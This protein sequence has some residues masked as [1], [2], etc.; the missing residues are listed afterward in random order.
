MVYKV[1]HLMLQ[2]I[3]GR[4]FG[5][6]KVNEHESD[7]I[8]YSNYSW[9]APIKT[10]VA[11]LRPVDTLG[12]HLS[13]YVVRYVNRY[14]Q[15]SPSDPMFLASSDEAVDQFRL[16]ASFHF[17]SFFHLDRS[18]V[19]VLCRP[20]PSHSTDS[21]PPSIFV[22]RFFESPKEMGTSSEARRFVQFV[23]KVLSMPRKSYRLLISCMAGF[24]DALESVGRNFDLAYSMMVYMLEALSK[25]GDRPKVIWD[26]YDQNVRE[27]LNQELASVDVVKAD[28]V[29]A[30][31]LNN[32]HL[33]LKKRFVDFI[34]SHVHDP[35]FTSEAE[36]LRFALAKSELRRALGN[37]YDARS[38]YVHDLRKVQQQLRLHWVGTENDVFH[39]INE[40]HITFAGL[41]RLSRHVLASF[42]EGQPTV[43]HEEYPWRAE[44]PGQVQM[45]L[46][47][48]YW[49]GRPEGF[50]AAHARERFSGFVDHLVTNLSKAPVP[51]LDLRPLMERIE[52][53][54]PS[55]KPAERMAMLALYAMF[56][57]MIP[58]ET[59]RP[60]WREFL[61]RWNTELAK[62]SIELLSSHVILGLQVPWPAQDCVLAFQDYERSRYMATAT[63]LPR[64][65]E[66]A[67]MTEIANLFLESGQAS[68]FE[69]WAERAILEASGRKAVQDQIRACLEHRIRI[70]V[71][72]LLGRTGAGAREVD[73]AD[74]RLHAYFKWEAAGRPNGDGVSFWLDAEKDLRARA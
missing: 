18:Y 65:A 52:M 30:I 73:E 26:D 66:I 68:E 45:A 4:F 33:K 3:S 2:I 5:K 54:A 56:N 38:G 42:I 27:R 46:A 16:L 17:Q 10:C 39:W 31:L 19:E 63:K 13:S 21:T 57:L 37:L 49:V 20:M 1:G 6:G 41:V 74:I 47:P 67:I 25:S 14:E 71:Q 35:Y 9:L 24:F 53:L 44:L 60:N 51:I 36:G 72:R 7:A 58:E 40:P 50:H 43:Q 69:V 59:R 28:K 55:A 64:L 32:P 48:Q 8:L 11:E 70:D 12:R 23:D 62:C 29:R 34:A 61:S 22:P 15:G